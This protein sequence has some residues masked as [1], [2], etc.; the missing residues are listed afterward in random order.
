MNILVHSTAQVLL[1]S[2]QKGLDG[3]NRSFFPHLIHVSIEIGVLDVKVGGSVEFAS[4]R[5]GNTKT[6]V[7]QLIPQDEI[8]G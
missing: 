4:N 6:F 3:F 2:Y 1:Q 8:V 5:G 7:V